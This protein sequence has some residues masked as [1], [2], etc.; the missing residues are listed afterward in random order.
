MKI[1]LI[2]RQFAA[3]GGAELYLQRLVA[4]LVA[5]GHDVHLYAENWEGAP[6]AVTLHRVN[7]KAPRALRPARFAEAVA[8][9]MAPVNYDVIFSLERTVSQDVYRAGDGVHKVWLDQRRRY[10]T[11][12]R[13]PFV[14][15]GAFH[16]NMMA[17]EKRTFDPA[18]TRHIIVNSDMVRQEILREFAYPAE[19]IH[20]VRNGVDVGRFKSGDR[21]LTRQR[22]GLAED[23]FTLLFVG[24]GWERKGLHFLLR[25]MQRLEK[26]DPQVKLLVVGKGRL[27][28]PAPANVIL[29]GPM[30]QVENAFAAADLLT[31]LPIY[32]PSSNVVPEAL[33]AGLP[34]ITSGF[35]GAAEWLTEGVN[36]HILPVPEDTDALEK[37]L[38]F[39]MARPQARPVLCEHPLDLET[40]VRETLRVLEQVAAEKRASIQPSPLG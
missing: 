5:A 17:L 3:T 25:L 10:A 30:P 40:N 9:R 32:E 39:W 27:R 1:A 22:F 15:M 18:V 29:T 4:S 12:W 8:Q 20:L 13:R 11:W 21:T 38:R 24:S 16:S 36:G 7:I 35:N 14:G 2:R 33:A 6:A 19:R 23:D 26:T 37:A 31:F 34:V 28:G